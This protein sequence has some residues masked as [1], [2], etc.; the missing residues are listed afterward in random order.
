MMV[1]FIREDGTVIHAITT[2][3]SPY[4]SRLIAAF[5]AVFPEY[6]SYITYLRLSADRDHPPRPTTIDHL[7][8][9]ERGGVDV[10][11]RL[12]S[13]LPRRS[14]GF[15]AYTGVLPQYRGLGLGRWLMAQTLQQVIEDA[16]ALGQPDPLGCCVEIMR[17]EPNQSAE[18]RAR[19]A[20]S[21]AFHQSCGAVLLDLAYRELQVSW[22]DIQNGVTDKV[23]IP[24]HLAMY[25]A[26]GCGSLSVDELIRVVEGIYLDV[27]LQT[28]DHPVVQEVI[29]AINVER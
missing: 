2:P 19:N 21:L 16:Q 3:D 24:K 28:V 17:V 10:G 1:E 23:G 5:R 25:F 27:Y 6:E 29:R 4:L 14:F 22:D 26:P 7:W 18:E 12:F 11:F 20:Q 13:Y 8:L 15:G 9:V